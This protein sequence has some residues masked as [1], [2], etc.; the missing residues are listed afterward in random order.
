MNDLSIS[1]NARNILCNIV[2][3][4]MRFVVPGPPRGYK[5]TTARSK[6]SKEFRRYAEYCKYVRL[7]ALSSGIT[8]PLFADK[9]HQIIIKTIA[10]FKNG[11]HCDPGN[12]NKGVCD[13]LFWDEKAYNLGLR[14]TKKGDDKHVGGLFPPPRYDPKEPRVI[15]I[16]KPYERKT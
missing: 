8:L 7:C 6:W 13:A 3:E 12:V 11:V 10:Y 2:T 15:V 16:I 1:P 9:D 5:T 4:K 14:N